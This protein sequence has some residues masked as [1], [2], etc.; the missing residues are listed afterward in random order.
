MKL[1][2][3]KK[4]VLFLALLPTTIIAFSLALY[5]S[6]ERFITID[7]A[8]H[9]NGLLLANH[10]AP[11]FEYGV[12]S[13]NKS[14]L[15]NIIDKTLPEID[16]VRIRVTD[17]KNKTLA[18]RERLLR[19]NTHKHS[20]L[21]KLITEQ[22]HEFKS[23]ITTS[24]IDLGDYKEWL[25]QDLK[26]DSD[27]EN[28]IGYVY[29]TVSNLHTR[30]D[31]LN[32]IVHALLITLSG[33]VLSM[34][35]AVKTS[36]GVIE[37]IQH[38][39]KAVNDIARGDTDTQIQVKSGGELGSLER[40]VQ[41]MDEEIQNKRLNLQVQVDKATSILKRTLDE[42]EIQNI[43]LDLSH[44]Q[45]LSASKTKS[46]FLAN[47]SH[48]IRTPMNG[49]LG[50]TDLLTKTDLNIEQQD[51]VKTISSSAESLLSVIDDI[52]DFSKIESGKL[53]IESISFSLKE[54]FND[55]IKMFA[56]LAY[57][58]NIELIYLHYPDVPEY[59]SGDPSRIRQIIINLIGN[60]IKFTPSGHII[61]KTIA[62]APIDNSVNFRFTISDTGIGMDRDNIDR[63]FNA[64][65]Q[66]DSSITRRFGGTGLG[67]V[68]S[69]K[70]AK[71]MNGD[72]GLESTLNKGSTFWFTVPLEIDPD[73][74]THTP[75]AS[76][77]NTD[78]NIILF[79]PLSKNRLPT[80]YLLNKLGINTIESGS[81]SEIKALIENKNISAIVAGIDRS[82]LYKQSFIK[83]LSS[84]LNSSQIPY[85]TLVSTLEKSDLK[86]I[87][88]QGLKNTLFRCSKRDFL[89][90]EVFISTQH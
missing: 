32:N 57:K 34:A 76:I 63:L 16:V 20:I 30:I 5:F 40:G 54:L 84:I 36:R 79:E 48:E 49:V 65:S 15:Y 90:M 9:K 44:N 2:S 55:I 71:L 73:K 27:S 53:N 12:F 89:E 77:S 60:A 87:N 78:T 17:K 39:T 62:T 82:T 35:L 43:E 75:I 31:Q 59:Y 67:L 86:N 46:E 83:E 45:A 41:K 42:L 70:L 66:A 52:L 56:A 22:H 61:I 8:L 1:W 80:R 11:A 19:K 51:Y 24:E 26:S 88:S 38:L 14:I 23:K 72:I 50:F 58:K 64:F 29:V 69:Q 3:I 37:P 47:M 7:E 85:L 81:L 6:I 18:L 68:I 10:L 4:R 13:E 25:N 74:L 21:E 33:L 28:V